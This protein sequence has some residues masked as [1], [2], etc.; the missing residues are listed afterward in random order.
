V[1]F[2]FIANALLAR[3]TWARER[4]QPFVGQGFELH[5]PLAAPVRVVIAPGARLEPGEADAAA[6]VTVGG[7]TGASALADE[8]RFLRK[9]L[10]PD[11]EEEL[12]RFVGDIAAR[13][14]V[15]AARS[16]LQWQL[17][18]LA[19]LGEAGVGYAVDERRALV[20]RHELVLLSEEVRAL[21]EALARLEAR[22][23]A[24]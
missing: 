3:E 1:A 12:S 17:D 2:C 8:L 21:E 4:L 9:H 5:L 22:V 15:G 14:I 11:I 19:R 10:R 18:A 23:K 13:R 6:I 20:R 7:V 16:F 24:L